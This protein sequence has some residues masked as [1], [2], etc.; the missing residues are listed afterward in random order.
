MAGFISIWVN[1]FSGAMCF[2]VGLC[3]ISLICHLFIFHSVYA[4]KPQPH[5]LAKANFHDMLPLIFIGYLIFYLFLY[6]GF[7][8]F[9]SFHWLDLLAA[10]LSFFFACAFYKNT[11]G[12]NVS[13][14]NLGQ[15]G[16]ANEIEAGDGWAAFLTEHQIPV[17]NDMG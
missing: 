9:R 11:K 6:R 13:F 1:G 2:Q 10:I 16:Q 14:R 15:L 7:M 8:L 3:G 17:S 12:I 4:G 5:H